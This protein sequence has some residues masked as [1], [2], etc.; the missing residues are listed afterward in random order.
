[1]INVII[2]YIFTFGVCLRFNQNDLNIINKLAYNS[3][4][5][6]LNLTAPKPSIESPSANKP[7]PPMAGTC[8]LTDRASIIDCSVLVVVS[9]P[10]AVSTSSGT[11]SRSESAID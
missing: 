8:L 10:T 7:M 9:S 1:M 5:Y 2:V 4:R 6:F 11:P 3:T